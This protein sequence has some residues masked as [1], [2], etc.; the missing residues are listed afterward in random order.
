MLKRKKGYGSG[1]S[2]CGSMYFIQILQLNSEGNMGRRVLTS[3]YQDL[4]LIN[5][6]LINMAE[7]LHC[8]PETVTT[9]LI[10]CIT[11]QIKKLKS[12]KKKKCVVAALPLHHSKPSP[13][14]I[15]TASIKRKK[16]THVIKIL[17]SRTSR[18]IF[19]LAHFPLLL[20]QSNSRQEDKQAA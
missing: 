18:S 8:S 12:K 7:F 20:V 4:A 9:L 14:L 13:V 6:V 16:R 3:S 5:L 17:P 15:C 19:L 10:G 1:S 2:H 11:L